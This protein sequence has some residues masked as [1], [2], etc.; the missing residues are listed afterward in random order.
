MISNMKWRKFGWSFRHLLNYYNWHNYVEAL[1]YL[2]YGGGQ[3]TC[4]LHNGKQQ[5]DHR[6]SVLPWV[7]CSRDLPQW[8]SV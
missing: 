2:A 6:C 1:V 8:H 7:R 4:L 3:F 5:I